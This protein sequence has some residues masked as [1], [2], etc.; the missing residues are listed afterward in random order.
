LVSVL[1]HVAVQS[2]DLVSIFVDY[3]VLTF[4][5]SSV[6]TFLQSSVL[7]WL[8]VALWNL[9]SVDWNIVFS[10]LIYRCIFL[11]AVASFLDS[12]NISNNN[13]TCSMKVCWFLESSL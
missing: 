8:D 7:I 1:S 2:T 11:A 6:L 13:R 3:D 4:L 10:K 9:S 5:K 12:L